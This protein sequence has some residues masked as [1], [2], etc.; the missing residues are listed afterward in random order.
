MPVRIDSEY[1]T[2]KKK[3]NEFSSIFVSSYLYH[4]FRRYV[5]FRAYAGV[6]V[7][8]PCILLFLIFVISVFNI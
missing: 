5:V 2:K 7:I 6:F 4:V 8:D 1:G 3:M